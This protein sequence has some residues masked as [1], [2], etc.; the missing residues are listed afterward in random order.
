MHF[1]FSF[2]YPSRSALVG[3]KGQNE[4]L[5][6]SVSVL[7]EEIGG[8]NDDVKFQLSGSNLTTKDWMGKVERERE[9]QRQRKRQLDREREREREREGE[10]GRER[11][12]ERE[13]ERGR[14]RERKCVCVCVRDI[15]VSL[16]L[17]LAPVLLLPRPG[18][19]SLPPF[20][21][22]SLAQSQVGSIVCA[23]FFPSISPFLSLIFP[24]PITS[25]FGSRALSLS[26]CFFIT[27][28][29]VP[30]KIRLEIVINMEIRIVNAES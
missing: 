24:P 26:L 25:N 23:R 27:V 14:E 7:A 19:F 4:K 20:V 21:S 5:Y 1:V 17:T 6:G 13:K 3:T 30:E 15:H 8:G 28:Q 2:W 29:P 12:R 16:S 18:S 22:L 10:R 9:R 11:E